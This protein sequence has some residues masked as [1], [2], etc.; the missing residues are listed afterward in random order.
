MTLYKISTD[1]PSGYNQTVFLWRGWETEKYLIWMWHRSYH[2][3]AIH[4]NSDI[5]WF[6]NDGNICFGLLNK[7]MKS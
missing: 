7:I 3:P 4:Y 5:K 1:K 6:Y 2:M